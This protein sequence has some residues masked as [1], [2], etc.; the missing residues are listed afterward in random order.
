M[1]SLSS[2]SLMKS[3][4]RRRR[5]VLD[6]VTAHRNGPEVL[7]SSGMSYALK[8]CWQNLSVGSSARS[9]LMI[10]CFMMVVMSV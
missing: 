1:L 3:M 8:S 7:D 5:C 9:W 10:S 4:S 2:D 6:S